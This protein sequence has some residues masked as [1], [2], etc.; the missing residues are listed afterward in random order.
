M[1]GNKYKIN[2]KLNKFE[3]SI[4]AHDSICPRIRKVGRAIVWVATDCFGGFAVRY[5]DI[6]VAEAGKD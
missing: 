1:C 4:L 6:F 5:M 2:F 3:R